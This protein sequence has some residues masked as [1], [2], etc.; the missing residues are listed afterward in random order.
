[1]PQG[2]CVFYNGVLMRDC[3]TESFRQSLVVDEATNSTHSRFDIKVSSLIFGFWEGESGNIVNESQFKSH[4]STIENSR[5][6]GGGVTAIDRM[7]QIQ[8]RLSQPRKDF[9]YAMTGGQKENRA[10][11]V[12][13]ILVAATGVQPSEGQIYFKG[14]FGEDVEIRYADK[15]H[16]SQLSTSINPEP[17]KIVRD[18]CFDTNNGPIT[19]NIEITEIWGG[20]AFRVNIEFEIHRTL[21][22][23][24]DPLTSTGPSS[25]LG[26]GIEAN[27]NVLSNTWS[28]EE[29]VGEDWRRTKV[30]EGTL[31]TRGNRTISD[32]AQNFR[33]LAVPGLL[34]GYKRKSM[35]F[36]TDPTNLVL[37][38]RIEDEQ[39]EAAPPEG[40]IDWEMEHTDSAINEYGQIR[41]QL[42]IRL[43]GAPRSKRLTLVAI[44]LT[45]LNARFPSA[46]YPNF[47][48]AQ[49]NP[50]NGYI[51]NALVITTRTKEPIVDLVCD[52]TIKQNT[53]DAFNQAVDA[54]TSDLSIDGYSPDAWPVPRP[55]DA[56][57]PVGIFGTYFQSPCSPW[58]GMP[59]VQ[60]L[61]V[62]NEVPIAPDGSPAADYWVSSNY[63]D[64][65][66][67]DSPVDLST[68]ERPVYT[69]PQDTAFPY[70]HVD[71]DCEYETTEGK[72]VLPLSGMRNLQPT[73]TE[74]PQ[75]NPVYT[76]IC[77]IPIHP[78]VMHRI[79]RVNC[80]RHGRP[81]ELPQP[82]ESLVDPN[83][84][85]EFL[86][87]TTRLV[88]DAPQ[89]TPDGANRI[90]SS[91]MKLTYVLNRPLEHYERFRSANNPA[92]VTAPGDNWVPGAAIFSRN[93]IEYHEEPE[94][95][96]G[97]GLHD[98]YSPVD[99]NTQVG[100]GNE[101]GSGYDRDNSRRATGSSLPAYPY[102]E[103]PGHQQE[104]L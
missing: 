44:A 70:T 2:T 18:R 15:Y 102:Y 63:P 31:R 87:G 13:Q 86:V 71:I 100:A 8:R 58:H 62:E 21:C 74:G 22:A 97:T 53:P 73:V 45:L 91:Q 82:A 25:T 89:L 56:K 32:W 83:G 81:P 3:K 41:R 26:I 4:P 103:Y 94:S 50:R 69:V 57:D 68:Y 78:P 46:S 37:K 79:L 66:V 33:H 28:S 85:L 75:P 34:R 92:L 65:A 24:I 23:E 76:N 54:S 93:R 16:P 17:Q 7:I 10:E 84:V 27:E 51:R 67:F 38:Y 30:V 101:V 90:F 29:T 49:I 95:P 48:L 42:T 55:Y 12:Y 5:D 11:D 19:K 88:L 60:R 64:Y 96:L 43:I 14:I 47:G 104:D 99:P 52:I 98:M 35:R 20:K 1:M 72:M 80:T 61:D 6:D 39:A 59:R 77:V 36:A 40:C 9:F